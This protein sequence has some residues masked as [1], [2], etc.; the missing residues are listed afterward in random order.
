MKKIQVREYFPEEVMVQILSK[1][2]VK[3]I[4]RFRCVCKLWNSII[5]TPHFISTFSSNKHHPYIILLHSRIYNYKY[6]M[7][8]DDK[9]F[10]DYKSLQTLFH[11]S[12]NVF[13][14]VLLGFNGLFC[15]HY[16]YR[17]DRLIGK[18][19]IWN[20][21]IGK[22][23]LIPQPSSC[24][25]RLNNI[26]GFGFDS[27]TNDY[28]LLFAWFSETSIKDVVLYS[29]NSNSW[30]QITHGVLNYRNNNMLSEMTT[31]A[32]VDGR[33]HWPVIGDH[34]NVVV[35]VFDLRD[36]MFRE[37]SLPECLENCENLKMI[38]FGESSIAVIHRNSEYECDIWAMKEY[39]SGEWMKLATIGKCWRGKLEVLEFRDNGE[40]LVFFHRGQRLA[41]YNT[42]NGRIKNLIPLSSQKIDMICGYKHVESL[43]LLNNDSAISNQVFE[44]LH[45]EKFM[46]SIRARLAQG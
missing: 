18:L 4:L 28:K 20:P 5:K 36:E 25:L 23:F 21:S 3:S 1:L 11:P 31:T 41:S 26:L 13:D 14:V 29:L 38:A 42:K 33:F 15:L 2:P 9:D 22:F 35:L 7:R 43:V 44:E 45:A 16:A 8:F 37:I 34:K 40:I 19:V 6:S 10:D 32:F 39:N 24:L 17:M 12:S 30:R 46:S 27:R